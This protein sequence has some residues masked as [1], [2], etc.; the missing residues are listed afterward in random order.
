MTPGSGHVELLAAG[1]GGVGTST[2][3]AVLGLTAARRGERVLLVDGA[4]HTAS[5]GPILG[6]PGTP[7]G[8]GLVVRGV[9]R[10]EE[11]LVELE[12]RL[13]LLPGGDPE[14]EL[15]SRTGRGR[16]SG[17]FRAVSG[18]YTAYDRVLVDGGSRLDTI[19]AS[20]AGGVGHVTLVTTAD[21]VSL[22]GAYAVVKVLATGRGGLPGDRLGVVLNRAAGDAGPDRA[23]LAHLREAADRFL[24]VRAGRSGMLPE[25]PAAL[26]PL[27]RGER[28]G[29][30]DSAIA[31]AAAGLLRALPED[32]SGPAR[33]TLPIEAG[34]PP[35]A[36][37]DADPPSMLQLID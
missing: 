13:D 32:P 7:P 17:A 21:R 11:L 19:V 18:L 27:A 36:A 14:P 6:H 1:R 33:K 2:V 5:L 20:A 9:A 16:L 24:G 30:G 23:A 34:S 31:L 29:F 22:A 35:R 12:P 15:V 37:S 8:L 28:A 10:P 26:A 25:D 4:E 3:C